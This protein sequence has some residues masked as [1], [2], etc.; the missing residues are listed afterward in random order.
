MFEDSAE[1]WAKDNGYDNFEVL[2][3]EAHGLDD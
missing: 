3:L 2:S 1:Q